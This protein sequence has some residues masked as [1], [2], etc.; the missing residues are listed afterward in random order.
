MHSRRGYQCHSKELLLSESD[1]QEV[2][3]ASTA[4]PCCTQGAPG[5]CTDARSDLVHPRRSPLARLFK[6]TVVLNMAQKYA[7]L[8]TLGM[9]CLCY[10]PSA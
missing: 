2:Q 6:L 5:C 1:I 3:P 4:P 7:A 8:P 10:G 9:Y